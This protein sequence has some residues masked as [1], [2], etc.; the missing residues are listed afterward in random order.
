MAEFLPV[1]DAVDAAH[2]STMTDEPVSVK[3]LLATARARLHRLTP[4]QAHAA[5]QDG[6][7]LIDIRS[8]SRQ[9][10]D[11]S[12]AGAHVVARSVLEWRLDPACPFRDPAFGRVDA[13]PVLLC[14]EG[15]QWSLA[16]SPR[17]DSAS[18]SRPTSSAAFRR[19]GRQECPC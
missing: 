6:A 15:Y 7:T 19:G 10:A 12:I 18:P 9:L 8:E 1:C 4:A 13:R 3:E 2:S 17:N 11:G 5:M 14:D 16:A